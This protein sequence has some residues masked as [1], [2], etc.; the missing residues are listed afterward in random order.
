M[1]ELAMITIICAID[2]CLIVGIYYNHRAIK[3]MSKAINK[4]DEP[5]AKE[6]NLSTEVYQCMH[7][8]GYVRCQRLTV[9]GDYC[10]RHVNEHVGDM[11][12]R[13]H[14]AS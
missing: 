7:G 6:D 5:T 3:A 14:G 11:K 10:S 13:K 8:I 4:C 2:I 1:N 12:P 9:M